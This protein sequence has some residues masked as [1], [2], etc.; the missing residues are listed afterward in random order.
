MWGG[1]SLWFW[2][3]FPWWLVM[4]SI[5]SC[6]CRPFVCLLLK[7]IYSV[8]LPIFNRVVCFIQLLS[9]MNSLYIL[10]INLLSGIWFANIFSH[11]IGCL[12]ILLMVFFVESFLIWCGPTVYFWLF[13]FV[14]GIKYKKIIPK[15]SLT[16]YDLFVCLFV[17][18]PDCVAFRILVLQPGIEPGPWQWKCWVLTTGPPGNSL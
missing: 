16:S 12:F 13:A 1:S 3:A 15:T 4:L 14:F 7:N 8:P 10:D 6:T 5:S 11:S 18:W 17:F 2:F 9:C